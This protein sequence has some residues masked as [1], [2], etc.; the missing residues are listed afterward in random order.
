MPVVSVE[1]VNCATPAFNGCG[2]PRFV[3]LSLNCTVPVIA[4]T[5]VTVA[6]K[7]TF[8]FRS[9]GFREDVTAVVVAAL[10]FVRL[11][12]AEVAPVPLAMTL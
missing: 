11:K 6:V 4:A 2:P 5:A 9:E 8:W 10:L 3:P 7:V 12:E 1:V